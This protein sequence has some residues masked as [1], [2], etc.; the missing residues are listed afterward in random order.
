MSGFEKLIDIRIATRILRCSI[1][2]IIPPPISRK[3]RS[4]TA[5]STTRASS[6][7]STTS[8]YG[9]FDSLLSKISP[10]SMQTSV[11][12]SNRS[13]ERSMPISSI[14]SRR[15]PM[16]F[17]SRRNSANAS[18]FPTAEETKRG[19]APLRSGIS[20]RCC[21]S[22]KCLRQRLSGQWMK[23]N[24]PFGFEGAEYPPGRA[25][26][27][28]GICGTHPL[29]LSRRRTGY[30]RGTRRNT[31]ALRVCPFAD[32]GRLSDHAVS[33]RGHTWVFMMKSV[34]SAKNGWAAI[35]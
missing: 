28:A 25:Q 31:A 3:N 35:P 2:S 16:C 23:E 11:N 13:T 14:R 15:L 32:G 18:A 6:I 33:S 17:P 34:F 8:F 20:P 1:H 29:P 19:C 10:H 5:G 4:V 26:E 24:K 12:I 30:D 27:Q 9:T 21:K 22:W 7:F